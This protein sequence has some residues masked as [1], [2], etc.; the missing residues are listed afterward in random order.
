VSRRRPSP[1]P[2]QPGVPITDDRKRAAIVAR[3]E[4]DALPLHKRMFRQA[5][6]A[7]WAPVHVL[8]PAEQTARRFRP[9]D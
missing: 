9:A 3:Q 8:T 4:F 6:D 7:G 1:D 2:G 5:P